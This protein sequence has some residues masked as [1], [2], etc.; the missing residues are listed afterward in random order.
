MRAIATIFAASIALAACS[1]ADPGGE[2]AMS[3]LPNAKLDSMAKASVRGAR[4]CDRVERWYE[5]FF[6]KAVVHKGAEGELQKAIVSEEAR[7]RRRGF[8]SFSVADRKTICKPTYPLGFKEWK[9][10]ASARLCAGRG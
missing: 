5:G 3:V 10:F 7:L 6:R 2:S 1:T 8:K 9:C 4:S